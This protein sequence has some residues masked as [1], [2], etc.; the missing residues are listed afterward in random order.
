MIHSAAILGCFDFSTLGAEP[1]AGSLLIVIRIQV[2]D[3]KLRRWNNLL[4]S[5]V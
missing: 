4:E 1:K 2:A 3:G 5:T